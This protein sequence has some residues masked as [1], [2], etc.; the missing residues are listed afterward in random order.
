MS[1]KTRPSALRFAA[2]VGFRNLSAP[3]TTRR[4]R[5]VQ[6]IILGL[7]FKRTLKCTT[8]QRE[9]G[10]ERESEE[11]DPLREFTLTESTCDF[12]ILLAFIA[13]DAALAATAAV[14]SLFFFSSLFWCEDQ[15]FFFF[16]YWNNFVIQY[17]LYLFEVVVN[18]GIKTYQNRI[19]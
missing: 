19:L 2:W 14:E 9:R 8:R 15:C 18:W 1:V 4:S 6:G 17:N 11:M 5:A 7:S 16:C 3:S 12:V 10:R 13:E